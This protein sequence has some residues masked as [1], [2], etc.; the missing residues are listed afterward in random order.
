MPRLPQRNRTIRFFFFVFSS[1][2]S[3]PPPFLS[4][5]FCFVF[6]SFHSMRK[7]LVQSNIYHLLLNCCQMT[8]RRRYDG[9][10]AVTPFRRRTIPH[11]CGVHMKRIAC[12]LT[13]LTRET[14]SVFSFSVIA[15]SATESLFLGSSSIALSLYSVESSVY[16]KQ[17]LKSRMKIEIFTE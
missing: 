10:I 13:G 16:S 14:I 5:V 3:S 7:Y 12:K 15:L 8:G 11:I 2:S 17:R 4:I 6:V 9:K 1:S